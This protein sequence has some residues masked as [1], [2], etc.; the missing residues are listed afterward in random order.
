LF[1]W[2]DVS[3]SALDGTKTKVQVETK[4]NK[5]GIESLNQLIENMWQ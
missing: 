4:P 5:E 1:F 2:Q 3:P